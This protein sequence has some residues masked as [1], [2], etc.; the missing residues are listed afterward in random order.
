MACPYFYP[1]ESGM[2]GTNPRA[3]MLPLGD[4]WSGL[5]RAVPDAPGRPD[6]ALLRPLCNLGYARGTCPSFPAGDGPDA[7]RFTIRAA[8][9]AGVSL[10]YVLERDHH[11]F[12]HGPLEYSRR[13]RALVAPPPDQN[14]N[15]QA[16]AYIE[17]YLRRI[18]WK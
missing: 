10:Y 12:A 17:S 7:V 9:D 3:A 18:E 13:E 14:L 6:N 8:N 5:C 4:S 11:P 16:L 15:R 2:E 1:V